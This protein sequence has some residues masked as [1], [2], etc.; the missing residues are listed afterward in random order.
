MSNR[1]NNLPVPFTF[2]MAVTAAGTPEKLGV[3]LIAATIALTNNGAADPTIT[4]SSSR[5]LKLGF[6]VNDSVTVSG[7]STTANNGT[8]VVK[9][10]TAGTLTLVKESSSSIVTEGASATI[11]LFAP[12][13]IPDGASMTVKAK[14]ANGGQIHFAD[15]AAKALSSSGGSFSLRN[16]EA[17]DLQIN[18]TDQLWID[19]TVS[20]EGVEVN[21]EKNLQS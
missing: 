10:V 19:A 9:A 20:S 16:N 18:S 21:F 2:Q 3:K 8:F 6:Q 17:I 13:S 7:A 1:T 4:D 11:K 5:F 14:Y 15:T 12:K